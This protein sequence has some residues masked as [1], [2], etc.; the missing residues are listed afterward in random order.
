MA[1]WGTPVA[2]EDDAERAGCGPGLELVAAIPALGADAG[3][4]GLAARA[5]VATGEAAVTLDAEGQ[6][7]VAGD[8]VN[9]ASRVQSA[10]PPGGVFV[11]RSDPARHRCRDRVRARPA[12]HDV[13][14]KAEPLAL[15]HALRV[16]ALR[17]GELRSTGLVPRSSAAN[18]SW[19][20]RDLYHES[21][22]RATRTCWP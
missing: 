1:V 10:A 14:G 19:P 21:Q 16:V 11:D 17:G 15:H 5:G 13:K 12:T 4:D 20:G 18:A 22:T 8:I 3:V 6:G 9:T 2:R 7:M